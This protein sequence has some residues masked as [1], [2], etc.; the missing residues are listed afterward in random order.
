MKTNYYF[1]I[2]I[3]FL[4]LFYNIKY[5]FFSNEIPVYLISLEKDAERRKKLYEKIQPDEY[6]AVNGS[7]LVTKEELVQNG[8]LEDKDLK[9]GQIGCYMSHYNILD[10]IRNYKDEFSIIIEDDVVLDMKEQLDNIKEIA[11]NAPSDW[12]IIFIGHNYYR[13]TNPPQHHQY[14]NWTFKKIEYMHG[15]QSYLIK[16]KSIHSKIKLLYP[17]KAPYDVIL[18]N[19]F[20]SYIVDPP[21]THLSEFGGYSNTESI[22]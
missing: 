21:L 8:K 22:L 12:E 17:I 3:V 19:I 14:N 9:N 6:S 11:N 4:L 2:F 18:P 16:N 13:E 5:E 7:K 15:A 1:I 10:K 20:I